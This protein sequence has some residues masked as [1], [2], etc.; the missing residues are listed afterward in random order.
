MSDLFIASE[1]KVDQK[2]GGHGELQ[3]CQFPSDREVFEE[4][5]GVSWLQTNR[6]KQALAHDVHRG[7]SHFS[8]L[9][10]KAQFPAGTADEGADARYLEADK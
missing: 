4:A 8:T 5:C 3:G 6:L 1:M 9:S 10:Q 2:S 7:W